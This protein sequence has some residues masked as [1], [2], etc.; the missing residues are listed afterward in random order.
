MDEEKL[1]MSFMVT[2]LGQMVKFH[3]WL[4]S[5]DND[6]SNVVIRKR[7]RKYILSELVK[8]SFNLRMPRKIW[9]LPRTKGHWYSF[10]ENAFPEQWL[11]AF[12]MSKSTFKYIHSM[13]KDELKPIFNPLQPLRAVDSDEQIA[14][15]LYF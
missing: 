9:E 3:E 7:G 5:K 1:M 11:E 2:Q 13:L 8:R 6:M 12:R 15:C 10:K 14:I 4:T